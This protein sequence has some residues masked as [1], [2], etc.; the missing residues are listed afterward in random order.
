MI[1][2]IIA[3]ALGVAL[4]LTIYHNPELI[5]TPLEWIIKFI[6][7]PIRYLTWTTKAQRDARYKKKQEE[8]EAEYQEA[9]KKWDKNAK[10]S[11]DCYFLMKTMK[12]NE[13]KE[14][15]KKKE[16]KRKQEI[17][18][19]YWIELSEEEVERME[20]IKQQKEEYDALPQEEKDRL[21]RKH[22][23]DIIIIIICLS[24]VLA[25]WIIIWILNLFWANI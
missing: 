13:E 18:N 5:T 23:R 7:W 16:E 3:V 20:R 17:I 19:K 10:I 4:G 24:I 6:T 1:W 12:E 11:K 9:L 15:I 22:K 2:T 25:P 8:M 21:Q 14:K